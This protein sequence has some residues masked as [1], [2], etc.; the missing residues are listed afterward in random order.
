MALPRAPGQPQPGWIRGQPQAPYTLEDARAWVQWMGA[1]PTR[2]GYT[3]KR[4]AMID[5]EQAAWFGELA[6]I[7]DDQAFA[8]EFNARIQQS[9]KRND[10]WILPAVISAL[11]FG[12]GAAASGA[13]AASSAAATSEVAPLAAQSSVDAFLATVPEAVP[14]TQLPVGGALT[15]ITTAAG[16]S[17]GIGAG[18]AIVPYQ[19]PATAA[20]QNSTGARTPSGGADTSRKIG[21][22]SI[23]DAAN[24][25]GLGL[26]LAGLGS[27][28]GTGRPTPSGSADPTPPALDTAG[29]GKT[30]TQDVF[31]DLRRRKVGDPTAL[32]GPGG[33]PFE[34]LTLG[35]PTILGS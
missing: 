22:L 23:G 3:P 19:A 6:G 15:D 21:D 30:P 28:E 14:G 10:S 11:T 8:N 4:G 26:T 13:T 1:G 34:N 17:A 2:E 35:R 9:A 31:K 29:S 32:T 16:V 20:P 24:V 7:K 27:Y 12:V 25:L 33:I 18:N 5:E